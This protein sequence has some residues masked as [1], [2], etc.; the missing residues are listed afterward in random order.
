MKIKQLFVF[1]CIVFNLCMI[2]N[3]KAQITIENIKKGNYGTPEQR[4][5]EL[6]QVMINGLHLDA[7]QTE[8]V[9]AI[10]LHYALRTEREI[11]RQPL[12]TWQKYWR[13]YDI[14]SDKDKELKNILTKEQFSKYVKKKNQ[15]ISEGFKSFFGF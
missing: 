7:L 6:N 12:S 14:Q 1:I 5:I 13:L 10:N 3:I 8:K 15:V 2:E 9:K 4:A 11:V